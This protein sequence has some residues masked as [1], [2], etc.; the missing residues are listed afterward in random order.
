MVDMFKLEA[1][2]VC[3]GR[4]LASDNAFLTVAS[5]LHV[6]DVLPSLNENGVEHDP[7]PE[8]TTGL[9]SSVTVHIS[10]STPK[11]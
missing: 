6:F 3:P 11:H 4:H 8:M 9:L 5:V 7:T 1:F 10:S 2:S